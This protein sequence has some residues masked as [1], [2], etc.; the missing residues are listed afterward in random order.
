MLAFLALGVSQKLPLISWS[1]CHSSW[2]L[3]QCVPGGD[4]SSPVKCQSRRTGFTGSAPESWMTASH[5][6]GPSDYA[7][8]FLVLRAQEGFPHTSTNISCILCG[9]PWT[10][11]THGV[12]HGM[13]L[14]AKLPPWQG[15]E[16]FF[17][18]VQWR[19]LFRPCSPCTGNPVRF[20]A[21]LEFSKKW[22]T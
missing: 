15:L 12:H 8:V 11:R 14:C 3:G 17:L 20:A 4:E 19:N 1:R 13:K 6:H 22:N 18:P 16:L 2:L 9:E 7:W 21:T 5:H 10:S